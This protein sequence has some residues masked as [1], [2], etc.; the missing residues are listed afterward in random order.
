[1]AKLLD[2]LLHGIHPVDLQACSSSFD[3]LSS[4]VRPEL[5][6]SQAEAPHDHRPL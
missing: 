6:L 1:M 2:V 4:L 3:V 5:R